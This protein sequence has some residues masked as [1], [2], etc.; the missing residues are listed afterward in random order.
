[1]ITKASIQAEIG[2]YEKYKA[3]LG[4]QLRSLP[5][6][7]IYDKTMHGYKRP[8]VYRD[9]K[10]HYLKQKDIKEIIGLKNREEIETAI[11]LIESNLQVLTEMEQ[12]ITDFD[13]LKPDLAFIED[14]EGHNRRQHAQYVDSL[15][16]PKPAG[17]K[18]TEHKKGHTTSDNVEVRSRAELVLYEHFKNLGL[19]FWYE[20][21]T[22]IDGILLHPD[23][24]IIH[25]KDGR[26]ILWEHC[27]MMDLENYYKDFLNRQYRYAAEGYLPYR[28]IVYSYDF[29]DDSIDIT[30]ID[31]ILQMMGII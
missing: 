18:R 25:P 26:V 14:T 5:K 8:H 24:T 28:N 27:G 2:F 11:S 19:T 12:R 9:G 4:K 10:E 15:F 3:R 6:G 31:K 29:G 16:D 30:Y 22:M 1:M 17:T 21:P 20:K 7:S 13:V 23:F